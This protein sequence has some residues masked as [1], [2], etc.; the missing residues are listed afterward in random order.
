VTRQLEREG[1]DARAVLARLR[2]QTTYEGFGEL[3]LVVE[4]ALESVALKQRIFS[5]LEAV[6]SAQCV[7]A[8]NTST[9]DIAVI[10]QPTRAQTRL[11]GLHFFSPA[12]VMPLLEIVRTPLTDGSVLAACLQLAQRIRKVPVV[13]ANC[14]GFCA[15]RVFFPYTQA[16]TLLVD[17]G[18]HPYRVDRALV[19]FGM[20]M[21]VFQMGD[22]SGLDIHSHVGAMIRGAYGE[23]CYES[24]LLA[25]LVEQKRLGQKT[26]AG[27]YR[28]EAGKTLPDEPGVAEA[29]ARAR[30]DAARASSAPLLDLDALLSDE[31]IVHVCLLP[32]ANE[33]ARVVAEGVVRQ[34]GDVDVAS[35]L[36]YG[37][38][39]ARGGVMHWAGRAVGWSTTYQRLAEF[40]GRFGAAN[41]AVR[42]FFEPSDALRLLA[43]TQ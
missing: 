19:R 6:C 30:A 1:R 27:V 10:A 11:V 3:E 35:V 29:L 42:A 32:V 28:Y 37:F 2:G 7:L 13:T 17:H 4:A 43:A 41:A 22:L 20:P 26:G 18:V 33:A 8:T 21:G 24:S 39:E 34:A 12:H 15:N 9:I 14:V 5:E 25:A 31:D 23:R 38:P 36:G 16:A 40:A